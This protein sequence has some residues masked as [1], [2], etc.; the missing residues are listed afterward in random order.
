MGEVFI[1]VF[2]NKIIL[3]NKDDYFSCVVDLAVH[4]V[5]G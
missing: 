1:Q 3:M 5:G 2:I 4:F